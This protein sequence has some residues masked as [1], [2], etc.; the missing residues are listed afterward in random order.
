[1]KSDL[2]AERLR[3]LLDYDAE[4]GTFTWRDGRWFGLAG[5]VA[6]VKTVA[7]YIKVGVDGR[8]YSAHRLAWLH[9]T[10]AWPA[11]QL[12]HI[13]GERGNNRL[14][15]LREATRTQNSWNKKRAKHSTTGFKG[16]WRSGAKWA[17][18]IRKNGRPVYLGT[19]ETAE[20]AHAAYVTAAQEHFGEFARSA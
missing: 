16:V 1:V 10:G 5:K 15:N 18:T 19:F 17:A 13:D 8:V 4:T 11:H 20:E 9:V 2:T 6:G 3:A 14:A 7:G 12:D